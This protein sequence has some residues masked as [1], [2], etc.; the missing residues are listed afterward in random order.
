[1]IIIG[2]MHNQGVAQTDIHLAN[3]LISQGRIFTIDGG[4]VIRKT[5][6]PLRKRPSLENLS[7]FFA[8]LVPEF[9]EFVPVVLPAYDAVR[10]WAADPDRLIHLH[11]AIYQSRES[12][13][14]Y[15]L[16]KVFRD[17][18][19]FRCDVTF[20]RFTVCERG[21][22]SQNLQ[23]LLDDPDAFLAKGTILKRAIINSC[24]G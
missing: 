22:H 8:Q 16:D 14:R 23:A 15:Y 18:T 17:C 24:T 10:G 1:M 12:R 19:R 21:E 5:K 13:K 7:W 20:N 2:K 3:F 11:R 9:D 6:P 4:E